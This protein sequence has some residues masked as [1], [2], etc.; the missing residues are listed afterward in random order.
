MTNQKKLQVFI[1]STYLD[2]IEERQAAV[3]AILKAGHIPAGME[4]FTASNKSQWDII[5]RWID[6]SDIYMLILGGRYGSIEN[7]SQKSYTHLE[8]EYAQ[9]QGKPLFAVVI[10]D[11]ALDSRKS[12]DIEKDNPERLN[13]FRKKVLSYMS[14]FF[15]DK[16][17]I[18]L[19]VH[20]SMGQITQDYNLTGW[21][22]GNQQNSDIAKEMVTLNDEL[23]KLREENEKFKLQQVK[24][25][26]R[27]EVSTNNDQSLNFPLVIDESRLYKLQEPIVT[28][29]DYLSKYLKQEDVDTYNSYL[30]EITQE[31]IAKFNQIQIKISA[32]L[33]AKKL[34]NIKIS[35]TGNIKAQSIRITLKFPDLV[36]IA[37]SKEEIFETVE[38]LM[39]DALNFI[40]IHDYNPLEEAET[41]LKDDLQS[42]FMKGLATAVNNHK[43]QNSFYHNSRNNFVLPHINEYETVKDNEITIEISNLMHN[44]DSTHDGFFLVPLRKGEGT[45]RVEV[46][47]EEYLEP[48]IHE[49][50]LTVN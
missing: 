19:A 6:E 24:R 8:Y 49:I 48:D 26:P 31:D 3:E 39:S 45:V 20:E 28:I 1:S 37:K 43:G 30:S 34:L 7:E 44:L 4:L 35:N 16:K 36:Y 21:I 50:M 22:R 46:H 40:P 17:D 15:I 27:L 25:L 2:L 47:C 10:E 29:P 11:S 14:S 12:R 32:L 13:E 18:K 41:K 9:S 38:K 42:D 33:N 23:R 5:T